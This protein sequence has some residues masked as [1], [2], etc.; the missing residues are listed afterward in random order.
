IFAPESSYCRERPGRTVIRIASIPTVI[1]SRP[2]INA[3]RG[4]TLGTR[5]SPTSH[6][7]APPSYD[8]EVHPRST[9]SHLAPSEHEVLQCQN[10]TAPANG[11]V[12]VNER[13]K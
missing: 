2:S 5:C 1:D 13:V 3:P 12:A 8:A 10:R 7:E 6:F 11:A 9:P 4:A